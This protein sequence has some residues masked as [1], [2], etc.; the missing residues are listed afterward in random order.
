MS[1][2]LRWPRC[3]RFGRFATF[4]RRSDTPRVPRK[5]TNHRDRGNRT[6]ETRARAEECAPRQTA[7]A[8]LSRFSGWA[9]DPGARSPQSGCWLLTPSL[10][11]ATASDR[12]GSVF[13]SSYERLS[14]PMTAASGPRGGARTSAR[15]ELQPRRTECLGSRPGS[16]TV[17]QWLGLGHDAQLA[18][19]LSDVVN[20]ARLADLQIAPIRHQTVTNLPGANN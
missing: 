20:D 7:P 17:L 10:V 13:R 6:T 2:V 11:G 1:R 8:T 4:Y 5:V 9:T 18:Q 12:C 3:G 19:E 15:A 14:R 16:S